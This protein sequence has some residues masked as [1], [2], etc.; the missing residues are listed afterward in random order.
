MNK[1]IEIGHM[2]VREKSYVKGRKEMRH[3]FRLIFGTIRLLII[4]A[5]CTILFYYGII[6]VNKE[7]QNYQRYEEP[8]GKAVKAIQQLEEDETNWFSRLMLFYQ[9]GE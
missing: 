7:F 5:G 9:M 8:K 6:W 3:T 2:M 1:S 4:L